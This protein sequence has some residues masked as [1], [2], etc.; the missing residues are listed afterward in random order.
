MAQWFNPALVIRAFLE[1]C[2][3]SFQIQ[4]LLLPANASWCEADDNSTTWE[5]V[6]CVS[7]LV[8]FQAASF[9]WALGIKNGNLLQIKININKL[10]L[11]RKDTVRENSYYM[12]GNI[13]RNQWPREAR[14]NQSD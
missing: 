6:T 7:N 14:F 12:F 4:A 3:K 5:P 2:F 10:K 11:F 13:P 8:E 9:S 1:S